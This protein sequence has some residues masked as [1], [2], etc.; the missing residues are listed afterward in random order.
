MKASLGFTHQP[1]LLIP[2][3]FLS[4]KM[5]ILLTGAAG[6]LGVPLF[7][8]LTEAGHQV[9]GVDRA[10][11]DNSP[12]EL[13]VADIL[14]RDTCYDLLQGIEAVVH[15]AKHSNEFLPD[16]QRLLTENLAMN[17]NIF[18][19]AREME[20][21]TVVFASSIQ[22]FGAGTKGGEND[23]PSL[24]YLPIDGDLPARPTNVYGLSKQLSEEMLRYYAREAD[25]SCTALRFP[26]L[27]RS[28]QH[29]NRFRNGLYTD[30]INEGWSYLSVP[31]A[32]ALVLAILK[33]PLPGFR[34]YCPAAL[35]NGA[36]LP[37]P[38]LIE[39]YFPDV[40]LKRPR[41]TIESFIDNSKIQEETGWS[42]Q[43]QWLLP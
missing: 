21:K 7:H 8:S 41:E 11:R 14:D 9:R 10:S 42:P 27:A 15:V 23:T 20:V 25:M 1:A 40:P 31:D 18:Q 16:K 24:A 26:F 19:T 28:P 17:T 22:A 36:K 43:D 39:R 37:V 3:Y 4:T 2:E 5:K 29:A 12:P 30:R 35:D 34:I 13:E 33:N 6:F 32:N 38:Q